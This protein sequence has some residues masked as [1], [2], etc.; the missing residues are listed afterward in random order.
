MTSVPQREKL[1]LKAQ[2]IKQI[3]A[4]IEDLKL[5]I[6]KESGVRK[7]QCMQESLRAN[8]AI[9]AQLLEAYWE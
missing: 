7:K 3:E 1:E 9:L 5:A 6:F 2:H 8:K 4:R